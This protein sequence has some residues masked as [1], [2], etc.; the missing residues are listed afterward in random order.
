MKIIPA[1]LCALACLG[2]CAAAAA[3]QGMTADYIEGT[4]AQQAG[5]AWSSL[6]VGDQVSPDA[7]IRVDRHSLLQLKGQDATITLSQPGT[8]ALRRV[9]TARASLRAAGAPAAVAAAFTKILRGTGRESNA[10]MGVR[11]VSESIPALR[12][13]GDFSPLAEGKRSLAAGDYD[14]AIA[15]FARLARETGDGE[16]RLSLATAWS[17]KGDPRSALEALSGVTPAGT[18]PWAADFFLL[19]AKLLVDTFAFDRAVK[20]LQA[21]PLAFDE[22]RAQAWYFLLALGWRGAGEAVRAAECFDAV[23]SLGPETGLAI[24]AAQLRVTP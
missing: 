13:L 23:V 4:A 17:L 3:A 24:A 2:P 21:H 9:M 8:Y 14:D 12:D 15:Q 19:Q 7:V 11:E 22:V 1:L 5:S 20:A 16:A 18:E 6:S 10:A